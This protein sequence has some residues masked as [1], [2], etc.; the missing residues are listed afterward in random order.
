MRVAK[1]VKARS[2]TTAGPPE[3]GL[4]AV[5]LHYLDRARGYSSAGL[6]VGSVG[7]GQTGSVSS[8]QLRSSSGMSN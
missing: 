7:S 8:K 4:T 6:E 1:G 2:P 3:G 5:G